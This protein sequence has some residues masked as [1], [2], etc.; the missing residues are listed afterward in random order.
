MTHYNINLTSNLIYPLHQVRTSAELAE[1]RKLRQQEY[2]KHYPDIEEF[3]NDPFD[4]EAIIL[5]GRNDEGRISS[6]CRMVIDSDRGLP[7]DHV[8]KQSSD[9]YRARKHK[10][11]EAGRFVIA[12]HS[13]MLF[14]LYYR[15]LYQV[16]REHEIDTVFLVIQHKSLRFHRKLMN[17]KTLPEKIRNGFGSGHT[18]VVVAWELNN[19]PDKF[20]SWTK[21]NKQT[22]A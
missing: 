10:L 7:E 22:S 8:F 2:E 4:D 15:V 12:E 14:Q 21:I 11:M 18:F 17:V 9:C 20:Y 5:F 13:N 3:D 6:T 19:T 1:V 16:A